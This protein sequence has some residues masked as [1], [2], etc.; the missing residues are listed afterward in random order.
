VPL[1]NV[2]VPVGAGWPL[3]PVTVT[4]TVSVSSLVIG[5]VT[6]VTLTLGESF[7]GALTVTVVAPVALL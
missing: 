7:T 2:T 3:A 6:A 1:A 5:V 4:E